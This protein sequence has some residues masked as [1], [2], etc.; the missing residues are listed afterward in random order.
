MI[1]F[2]HDLRLEREQRGVSLDTL[3]ERTKVSVRQ[4][5]Q[6][7]EGNY[8]ALPG[9][10]FRKGFVRSYL[11]ALELDEAAWL[12]RF[13]TSYQESGLRSGNEETEWIA[14]AENVKNH[15]IVPDRRPTALRW[16][17][18]LV[19]TTLVLLLAWGV[20]TF[21]LRTRVE[22]RGRSSRA[23]SSLVRHTSNPS[24]YQCGRI[25]RNRRVG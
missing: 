14:F 13:D 11:R 21:V 19:L 8:A 7:E 18:L 17:G 9:G 23:E 6:L 24:L 5:N 25:A 4:L 16:I 15:R 1:Q 12:E 10:I 22:A 3:S 20:W 2:G